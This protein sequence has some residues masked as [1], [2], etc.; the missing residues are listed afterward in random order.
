MMLTKKNYVEKNYNNSNNSNNLNKKFNNEFEKKYLIQSKNTNKYYINNEDNKEN[1]IIPLPHQQN[2][3]YI[4]LNI[5]DMIFI[6]IQMLEDQK[7]PIPYI[8]SSDKRIFTFSLFL[9]IFGTIMLLLS[10]LM[11]SS[12][13]NF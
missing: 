9:I 13:T 2:I 6:I 12:S 3:E 8:L 11:K 10:S 7:N 5:R 4:I 1:I